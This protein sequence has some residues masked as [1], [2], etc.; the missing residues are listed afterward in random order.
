MLIPCTLVV[1]T[2]ARCLQASGGRAAPSHSLG[3]APQQPL[4]L[5]VLRNQQGQMQSHLPCQ[6]RLGRG[7]AKLPNQQQLQRGRV[8]PRRQKQALEQ[9]VCLVLKRP[10]LPRQQGPGVAAR[11]LAPR[12]ARCS[13]RLQVCQPQSLPRQMPARHRLQAPSQGPHNSNSHLWEGRGCILATG[14]S[15]FH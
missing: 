8:R 14:A 2:Q 15:G 4:Q 9:G 12:G 13:S 6:L 10:V 5:P 3:A 7:P 1:L 11:V